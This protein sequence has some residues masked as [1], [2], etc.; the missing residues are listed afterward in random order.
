MPSTSVNCT[1]S[2][3]QNSDSDEFLGFPSHNNEIDQLKIDN[4]VRY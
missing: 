4:Y 3:N 1:T 2:V